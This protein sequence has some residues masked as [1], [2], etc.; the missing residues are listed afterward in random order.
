MPGQDLG[1]DSKN[2]LFLDCLLFLMNVALTEY[3]NG[4]LCY[5]LGI[6]KYSYLNQSFAD[7]HSISSTFYY[8]FSCLIENIH[9]ISFLYIFCKSL[10]TVICLGS[11]HEILCYP[12]THARPGMQVTG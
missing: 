2:D 6:E 12:V 5:L 3:G 10:R 1:Q 4:S 7:F 8:F 11:P 9:L